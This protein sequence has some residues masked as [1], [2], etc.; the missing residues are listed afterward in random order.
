MN[1]PIP[2]ILSALLFVILD[3]QAQ[4]RIQFNGQDLF[5]NGANLAWQSFADDIGP[6][7]S[8][9]DTNHFAS[10]FSQIR[11]N[12]GNSLRLWLHTTGGTTPAWSG[13]TVTS[14]GNGTIADLQ[15]ILNIAW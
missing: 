12:G 2:L 8:T 7:P 5:L 13:S 9:P 11:A 4:N 3:L 14:P 10:V 1:K 6:N 15:R